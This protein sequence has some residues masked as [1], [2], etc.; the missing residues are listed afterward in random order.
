MIMR[1]P[2]L[3]VLLIGLFLLIPGTTQ[4]PMIDRD[5]A[6]FAQASKQMVESGDYWRIKMQ[7][8]PRHRKPPGYYWMQAASVK[9]SGAEN[10]VTTPYR[11]PALLASLLS[12][13][14]LCYIAR[15]RLDLK[16][17]MTAALLLGGNFLFIFEAH[18]A[19]TDSS[20]LASVVFIFGF[21]WLAYTQEKPLPL[22]MQLGLWLAV[23]AGI[24]IKGVAPLFA[25]TTILVLGV[26]DRSVAWL[27]RTGII[28]GLPLALFL[29][30]CWLLPMNHYTGTNFIWEIIRIDFLPKLQGGV[31]SH[32]NP[33]GY[34]FILFHVLFWPFTLLFW[35]MIMS[36]VNNF[37]QSRIRFLAVWVLANWIPLEL[38]PT[39]LPGYTMP[40]LPAIALLGAIAIF[41]FPK[42]SQ[43][44]KWLHWGYFVVWSMVSL[45][46]ISSFVSLPWLLDEVSKNFEIFMM[47][48][49]LCIAGVA[50]K[51][52][53]KTYY[54]SGFLSLLGLAII[55]NT[56]LYD[57]L[58]PRL[59][60]LWITEQ[61]VEAIQDNKITLERPLYAV[62]Y[63]EPSLIFRLGTWKVRF[64][65]PG[66]IKDK[67]QGDMQTLF[68]LPAVD[69]QNYA[70]QL[71]KI[72]EINGFHYSKGKRKSYILACMNCESPHA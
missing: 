16:T 32:G 20:L 26:L 66:D 22:P 56:I 39:K 10:N 33:P 62:D 46:F 25:V 49:S 63:H 27:K 57:S 7:E 5:G 69:Y 6:L 19:A 23:A 34:Y 30:L 54:Y 71:K 38:V 64:I 41:N 43:R 51:Y 18:F 40:L 37:Q 67:A 17:A 35:P 48:L 45:L 14:G 70:A 44:I 36:A 11:I 21:L 68:L 47:I 1:Y 8:R 61:V 13:L 31:E 3:F 42:M 52:F 24:C 2:Y 50:V 28:W 29:T 9:L 53:Y 55:F 15:Q 65:N 58:L 59:H 4:L 72:A 12:L 60:S